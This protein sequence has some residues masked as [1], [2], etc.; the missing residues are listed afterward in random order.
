MWK[1]P[2]GRMVVLDPVPLGTFKRILKAAGIP[3]EMFR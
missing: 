2:D 1:H 3:E